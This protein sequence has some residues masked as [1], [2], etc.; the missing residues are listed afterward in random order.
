M[1]VPHIGTQYNMDKIV[2]ADMRHCVQEGLNKPL[3]GQAPCELVK[4]VTRSLLMLSKPH[5]SIKMNLK[6]KASL[7]VTIINN[8]NAILI[9][10]IFLG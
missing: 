5:T 4:L 2:S 9:I 10:M 6:I 8:H 7:P 1:L 3:L